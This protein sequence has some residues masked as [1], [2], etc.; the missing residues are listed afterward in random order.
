MRMIGLGNRT[1]YQDPEL[2]VKKLGI[3]SVE[4][5]NSLVDL[6]NLE[7]AN[8]ISASLAGVLITVYN[9]HNHVD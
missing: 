6:S 7:G 3:V 4:I 9:S 8:H 1:V 5:S 2:D